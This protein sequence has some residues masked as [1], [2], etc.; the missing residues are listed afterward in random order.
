MNLKPC[1]PSLMLVAAAC[2]P[3]ADE[4]APLRFTALASDLYRFTSNGCPGSY[5]SDAPVTSPPTPDESIWC[6][7]RPSFC[8]FP[9]TSLSARSPIFLM[10]RGVSSQRSP[11]FLI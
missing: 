5:G 6:P 9:N 10:A 8:I 3:P 2:T 11:S 1:L 4:P 7:P